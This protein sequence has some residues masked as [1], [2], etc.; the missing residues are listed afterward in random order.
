MYLILTLSNQ[1]IHSPIIDQLSFETSLD[2]TIDVP[3]IKFCFDGFVPYIRC[4]TDFGTQCTDYIQP[5]SVSTT[6]LVFQAPDHF[7]LG[8]TT[9]RLQSN[10]SFLKFDYYTKEKQSQLDAQQIQVELFHKLYHHN[11]NAAASSSSPS[12]YYYSVPFGQTDTIHYQLMKRVRLVPGLW[13]YIGVSPLTEP[14]YELET[15]STTDYFSTRH[16]PSSGSPEPL[17]SLQIVPMSI[18]TRVYREQKAFAWINAMGICGGLFGLLFSLQ[19]CLFGYRP[20]SPWGYLHRWSFGNLRSSLMLGLQ[21]R[22]VVPSTTAEKE[23]LG[24]MED[25]LH[26]LESLFQAYYID[27]EI[28]RE[29]EKIK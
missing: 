21:N 27:D 14:D 9:S 29:L 23:R 4:T 24:K 25:R 2:R 3:D 7:K 28:F 20:R 13:N 17:G 16:D 18:E 6:C 5:S 8:Q 11:S 15:I 26:V 19:S 1:V 10:G 22:F 12:S